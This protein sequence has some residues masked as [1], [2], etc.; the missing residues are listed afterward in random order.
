MFSKYFFKS[1]T[2][3]SQI[4]FVLK[5]VLRYYKFLRVWRTVPAKPEW[6]AW[7]KGHVDEMRSILAAGNLGGAFQV[8]NTFQL[9]KK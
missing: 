2:I 8:R 1:Y 5:A 7:R 9:K 6:E 3:L 4:R